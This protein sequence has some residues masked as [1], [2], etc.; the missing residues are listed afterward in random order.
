MIGFWF[1]D[2]RFLWV[3]LVYFWERP[4]LPLLSCRIDWDGENDYFLGFKLP[5]NDEREGFEWAFEGCFLWRED[6]WTDFFFVEL[7]SLVLEASFF[8]FWGVSMSSRTFFTVFS[9]SFSNKVY[10]PITFT[11]TTS[12]P[13]PFS[14]SSNFSLI[15]SPTYLYP[16]SY[17]FPT[18]DKEY[19][20]IWVL[21]WSWVN[22]T[23]CLVLRDSFSSFF[24]L[25]TWDLLLK[26]CTSKLVYRIDGTS[27][28][29][30]Y[31]SEVCSIWLTKD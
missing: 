16:F 8:Y 12:S 25:C 28:S 7:L 10:P 30:I 14:I 2:A 9:N 22:S 24:N 11:S 26:I 15:L 6:L 23:P 3:D 20:A 1:K 19:V 21:S 13:A 27:Y 29:L 31:R 4:V 5:W 17:P 18:S